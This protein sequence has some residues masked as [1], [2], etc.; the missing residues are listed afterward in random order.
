MP[1][2]KN[3]NSHKKTRKKLYQNMLGGSQSIKPDSK[4]IKGNEVTDALIDETINVT[5]KT[6]KEFKLLTI[7]FLGLNNKSNKLV[8]VYNEILNE[9]YQIR[10]FGPEAI[11]KLTKLMK[12][13]FEVIIVLIDS[14]GI[15]DDTIQ[16]EIIK[17]IITNISILLQYIIETIPFPDIINQIEVKIM[18]EIQKLLQKMIDVVVDLT[19]ANPLLSPVCGVIK[20]IGNVI[21]LGAISLSV[22]LESFKLTLN[23]V[24]TVSTPIYFGL[25]KLTQASDN[26]TQ[27]LGKNNPDFEKMRNQDFKLDKSKK[28]MG[29]LSK[30]NPLFDKK[31]KIDEQIK[32][33][34]KEQDEL[35]EQSFDINLFKPN[36]KK[37]G[38]GGK[39][40]KVLEN[41][42]L[43]SILDFDESN[44]NNNI[45]DQGNNPLV[46]GN[47]TNV[48]NLINKGRKIRTRTKKTI[49]EFEI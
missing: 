32:K 12:A 24:N 14:V 43:N 33:L 37:M 35:Y 5:K 17:R 16:K 23:V 31:Q 8:R 25:N 9:I 15:L 41:R 1:I 20:T 46:G 29:Q 34:K 30:G 13:L 42:I 6:A 2:L 19:C 22:M 21:N 27:K 11:E 18:P 39:N 48:A 10:G 28:I 49:V 3:K 45:Y 44:L 47:T 4:I 26:F 7:N 36:N 38:G 40:A